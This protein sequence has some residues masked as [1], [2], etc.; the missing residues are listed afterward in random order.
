[1]SKAEAARVAAKALKDT[2]WLPEPLKLPQPPA[3]AA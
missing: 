2:G 1:M 3:L